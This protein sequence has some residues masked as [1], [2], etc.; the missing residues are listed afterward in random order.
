MS[1]DKPDNEIPDDEVDE[2]PILPHKPDFEIEEDEEDSPDDEL[3]EK[4]QPY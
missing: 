4:A 3:N 2:L 1:E